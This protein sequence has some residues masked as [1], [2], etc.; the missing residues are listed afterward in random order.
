MEEQPH[1]N[2]PL[3]NARQGAAARG[4]HDLQALA[5]GELTSRGSPG[6]GPR[7]PL[8]RPPALRHHERRE[9]LEVSA[10]D[11]PAG[12]PVSD[13][14]TGSGSRPQGVHTHPPASL[15]GLPCPVAETLV[16]RA[17]R[18]D[19]NIGMLVRRRPRW[20]AARRRAGAAHRSSPPTA[21]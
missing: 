1:G 7:P 19:K 6:A 2:A 12:D 5:D 10:P 11:Q 17:I 9:V 18:A 16:A 15:V 20:P 13:P 4:I 14:S 3:R 21:P 8:A